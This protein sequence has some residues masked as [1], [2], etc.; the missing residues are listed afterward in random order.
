LRFDR[1]LRTCVVHLNLLDQTGCEID[2]RRTVD[3]PES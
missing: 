2:L 3:A 1:L